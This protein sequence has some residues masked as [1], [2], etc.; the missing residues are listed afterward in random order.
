MVR[1]ILSRR[2]RGFTLIE[3]LVVI[4]II[5]I[6]IGLLLPA[7][8]KVREAAARMTCSNNLK[9]MMTGLHNYHGVYNQFPAGYQSA[10]GYGTGSLFYFLLPY[11]E[12]DNLFKLGAAPG[13]NTGSAQPDA[14]WGSAATPA[15]NS[16]NTP[17][18]NAVKTYMCPS[19]P[20]NVPA[21]TWTNGWVVG[22]YAYNHDAFGRRGADNGTNAD[23]FHRMSGSYPD[24]TSNTI[25]LTEKRANNCTANGNG[26]GTLW[27]HGSWNPWWEPRFNSYANRGALSIFQVQP[28]PNSACDA[29]R[30][31][32]AHSGGINV[33]LMDGSVRFVAQNINPT[34]WAWAVTA[35][36]GETLPGNW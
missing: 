20:N 22:N 18:A 28:S 36:G 33:A 2:W 11:I 10:A 25:G 4:A 23:V 12:Q 15:W 14:Y 6:L 7:V 19:D 26:N 24:G 31:Q 21:A 17:G 30:P 32:S 8:Q 29:S 1:F 3:L 5:A 9:Q 13:D 34:T 16:L 27:A 35:D